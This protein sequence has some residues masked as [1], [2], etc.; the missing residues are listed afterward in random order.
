[1]TVGVLTIDLYI[2][3][4]QSL[5]SRRHIVK[6]LTD[7]I[8][9]RFNVSCAEVSEADVW[10]RARIGVACVNSDRHFADRTLS[11]IVDL[12]VQHGE[13]EVLDHQIELI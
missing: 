5:K 1:M 8:R 7:R 11:Q 10:Q 3:E 6:S 12:I 2:P 13:A 9:A 4:S